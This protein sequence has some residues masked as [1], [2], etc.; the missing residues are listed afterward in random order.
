MIIYIQLLHRYLTIHIFFLSERKKSTGLQSFRSTMVSEH[1]WCASIEL[2]TNAAQLK[3]GDKKYNYICN[4]FLCSVLHLSYQKVIFH[5][6]IWFATSRL[7]ILRSFSGW[8]RGDHWN[9][10]KMYWIE[11]FICSRFGWSS[12][13]PHFKAKYVTPFLKGFCSSQVFR[14]RVWRFFQIQH[15]MHVQTRTVSITT[16]CPTC[17]PLIPCCNTGITFLPTWLSLIRCGI[18]F[19]KAHVTLCEGRFNC[20]PSKPLLRMSELTNDCNVI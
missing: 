3:F 9:I 8:G 16:G 12:F 5:K 11:F 20:G 19:I 10:E 15:T 14:L 1:S 13:P 4:F 18:P 7:F 2:H 17:S 6:C